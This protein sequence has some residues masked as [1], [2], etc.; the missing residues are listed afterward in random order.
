MA[1]GYL[2]SVYLL[3]TREG[4][5]GN[6]DARGSRADG[7]RL[8]RGDRHG[9]A[10]GIWGYGIIIGHSRLEGNIYSKEIRIIRRLT[11]NL[12]QL[13]SVKMFKIKQKL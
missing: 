9:I 5:C 13:I 12:S 2:K 8:G 11:S 1:F 4:I 10:S 6:F 7:R 3:T